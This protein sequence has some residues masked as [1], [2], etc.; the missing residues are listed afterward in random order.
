MAFA[1][2]TSS[3]ST[4]TNESTFPLSDQSLGKIVKTTQNILLK[5][6]QSRCTCGPRHQRAEDK[7]AEHCGE[8]LIQLPYRQLFVTPAHTQTSTTH[9]EKGNNS[10]HGTAIQAVNTHHPEVNRQGFSKGHGATRL[11]KNTLLEDRRF[12]PLPPPPHAAIT[13]VTA[14][15]AIAL[16]AKSTTGS[17]AKPSLPKVL[18]DATEFAALDSVHVLTSAFSP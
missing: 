7:V 4:S 3:A 10:H 14:A 12:Q 13:A 6:Y 1:S 16:Q 5:T 17:H 11:R 9:A 2:S 8:V 15:E 18:L